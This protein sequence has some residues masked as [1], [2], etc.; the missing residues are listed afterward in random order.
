MK[1]ANMEAFMT[2][3]IGDLPINSEGMRKAVDE[4]N[5]LMTENERLSAL[6]PLDDPNRR[7]RELY[8]A[9]LYG[10]LHANPEQKLPE[11]PNLDEGQLSFRISENG[12]LV[13][14]D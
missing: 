7:N 3:A 8:L 5:R 11:I 6:L 10:A 2:S 4:I 9:Y 13:D 1:G 12:Q 14:W